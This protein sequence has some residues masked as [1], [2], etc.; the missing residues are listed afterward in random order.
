MTDRSRFCNLFQ[1]FSVK[2][3][4]ASHFVNCS[5][6]HVGPFECLLD[7]GADW[8]VVSVD[9]WRTLR[10]RRREGR[11][12]LYGIKEAPSEF[13]RA[14]GSEKKIEAQ[15]SFHAWVEA[16]GAN[17]PRC[18]AKFR[19]VQGAN[20]SIIGRETAI[21]M[22]LLR[23]GLGVGSG[24]LEDA[25]L[26]S[27]E[28][29]PGKED[30]GE[31]KLF[32][33]IPDF[34]LD[35]DIDPSVTPSVKA[36][37]NI[38]EAFKQ[39]ATKRL[40]AM[41]AQGIIEKVVEAP[42]WISG[43]SAVP[44]GKDD[45]R[46]VVNMV[47]PNRAIR[48]RFFKMPTLDDIKT[49]LCGSRYF[50]K[51]DLKSAY[52]HVVIGKESSKMTTFMTPDGMYRFCRLNFGVS[53][54]PEAFQQKMEEILRDLL[55]FLIV[56]I[57]DILIHARDL[58]QLQSHT[59]TV[60]ARLKEYNL[61]LNVEKCEFDKEKLEF[62]GHQVSENGLDI[63]GKK[64]E[65]IKAFRSPRN[66]SEV[67]SFMGTA[68]FLAAYIPNFADIAKPLWSVTEEGNFK[69]TAAEEHAFNE[70]KDAIINCTVTQ[71][72][73]SHDDRTILYTDASPVA[74]GAVLVQENANAEAG[75]RHRII[76]FASRLLSPTEQRYPQVQREGLS[77]VW[78]AEH[79]WYYLV[80]RKFTIRTDNQ[81]IVF[82][83]KRDHLQTKRI[84]KR[85]DAWALRMEAFDF[86]I[87]FIKGIDNIADSSSRL[88]EGVGETNFEDSLAP[89]E[90]MCFS[91]DPPVDLAFPKG[92]VTVNEVR[93]FAEQDELIK[94]VMI[95]LESDVWPRALGKYRSEKH[96]LRVVDN[97]LTR[98][99]ELVIPEMLRPKVL[100][101]AHSGHPGTNAM[102]SILRGKVW[103][104]GIMSHAGDW[105]ARCKP[106][107][108]MSKRSNPQPMARSLLPGAPWEK[109]AV[110]YNGPYAEHGDISILLMV[111]LYSRYL[112]A[113]PVKG[114][115]FSQLEGVFFDVFN[116]FGF[117]KAIRSDNG[118]PFFGKEYKDFA[119][120]ND[121]EL[122]FSTPRDAQQNGAA[123][124]YMKLV[125]KAM[126]A[127]AVESEGRREHWRVS[128]A[129]TMA[130]HNSA[131]CEATGVSPDS[132]M[133]GRTVRR[134]LPVME[135]TALD[136]NH[137]VVN[138]H[139]K[140]L[141]ARKKLVED[142]RRGARYSEVEVGDKVYV[143]RQDKRK[144][145]TKFDPT[146][147]TVI[148]KD[149]GTFYLLSPRGNVISRTATFIKKVPADQIQ[150][151][152]PPQVQPQ[153]PPTDNG[154]VVQQQANIAPEIQP[155]RSER[156]K[157]S[158]AHLRNY[159]HLLGWNDDL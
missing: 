128:L 126:E 37:V 84:M 80:G 62:L 22:N 55:W 1:I 108:L 71:G 67:R 136:I 120:E 35:F 144:G 59:R 61:S 41:E 8:N 11:A 115:N 72:F 54:A 147:L 18:F 42:K 81:G 3:S 74:V 25:E 14:F 38:P 99:G 112:V 57:D 68:S 94:A 23:V 135:T 98:M 122:T 12:V 78:G 127:P 116:T 82:I 21:E 92:R 49:K 90:I 6:G 39:E 36:F 137:E 124:V 20:R 79:Y 106:C 101:V 9:D 26:Y 40:R 76:A 140:H 29:A 17:K 138:A 43:L 103:W 66:A 16:I 105:V 13:A 10:N 64:V 148:R 4:D 109:I 88:V 146:E 93:W 85:A 133:F 130:A 149:R 96:E 89:G 151:P 134:N 69:W 97:L 156:L 52:H 7:S 45:F 125:N 56:Y 153:M 158:A 139:D 19:V 113:R 91:L 2:A 121:I 47:A 33:S 30:G 5:I 111:D 70:L 100:A 32:P 142:E 141:K 143:A 123:E 150:K 117:V 24:G 53:S 34:V 44:K 27:V 95:A 145:Q 152:E 58:H 31:P 104:P 119:R 107:T 83:M 132:L 110:D 154:I 77:V 102:K 51:L 86:D 159:I 73:F 60:L 87:E 114:P 48:R 15:R 46:L 50:T 65:D 28:G 155:R 118:A 63:S 131:V 157:N 129:N 75:K